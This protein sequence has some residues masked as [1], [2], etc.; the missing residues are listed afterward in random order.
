MVVQTFHFLFQKRKN[1]KISLFC[2]PQNHKIL[3]N[4]VYHIYGILSCFCYIFLCLANCWG[5]TIIFIKIWSPCKWIFGASRCQVHCPYIN[6]SW[7][8]SL[9]STPSLP[10]SQ[11]GPKKVT[12][13]D[14]FSVCSRHFHREL[15][16]EVRPLLHLS[17]FLLYSPY[18]AV[19]PILES[20]STPK[21]ADRYCS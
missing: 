5:S 14:W 13:F 19:Y 12:R 8:H 18:V 3:Y 4:M 9:S 17:L 11:L 6:L 21:Q 7:Q 10:A 15:P 20:P 1:R 16:R 2:C